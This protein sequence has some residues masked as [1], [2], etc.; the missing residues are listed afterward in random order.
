VFKHILLATDGSELADK[1]LSHGLQLA[2]TLGARVTAVTVTEPWAA[3]IGGEA[4]Y[5]FPIEEYEKSMAANAKEILDKV[6]AAA[7]AAGV[8]CE[9]VHVTN[10]MPAEGILDAAK[11]K[12]AD[13]IVMASH[14]RS[15]LMKLL[16]GSQANKVV[17]QSEVPVLICR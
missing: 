3:V 5:A 10:K 16:L 11:E 1:A 6:V 4:A 7:K 9:T 2:K 15:G 8:A 14:G 17:T 13:L 12:G